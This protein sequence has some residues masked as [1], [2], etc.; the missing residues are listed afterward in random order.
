M[1]TN[2]QFKTLPTLAPK[3]TAWRHAIIAWKCDR[4]H[5]IYAIIKTL[6]EVV[7]IHHLSRFLAATKQL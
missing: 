1:R 4:F 3:T 2:K 5:G 7:V 6:L